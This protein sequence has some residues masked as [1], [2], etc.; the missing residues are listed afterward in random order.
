MQVL[1]LI[2]E[3]L[4]F[5]V[6]HH[7]YHIKNYILHKGKHILMASSL[8]IFFFLFRFVEKNT[9]VGEISTHIF[10]TVCGQIH[11]EDHQPAGRVLQPVHH[12][13]QPVRPRSR[14]PRLQLRPLQPPQL[15]HPRDVRVH[16]GR[17]HQEPLL[18]CRGKFQSNPGQNLLCTNF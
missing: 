11:E 12:Q 10:E 7:T 9:G 15:R 6:E 18:A 13:G 16:Q 4:S 3:L 14:R 8:L 1:G 5:F 17:G 2:L